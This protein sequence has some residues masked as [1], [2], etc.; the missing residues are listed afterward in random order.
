MADVPT[1]GRGAARAFIAFVVLGLGCA[2]PRTTE[3][4]AGGPA[5]ARA[6]GSDPTVTSAD[7]SGAPQNATLDIHVFGSNFDQ[8]S[9]VDF[10]RAGVVDPKLH[11]NATAFLSTAELVA[12]VSIAADAA[13]VSYDIM[14]TKSNGKKGIGTEKF[15]VLV[16]AE[17]LS[18]P[19]GF[20]YVEGMSGNGLVAGRIASSC[21]PG[22]A[23]AVWNQGQRTALPALPGTCGGGNATDVNN[24]GVAV[25]FAY[26]GTS[27]ISD[28]RWT[29]SAGTYQVEALPRL[30]DGSRGGA[31]AINEVGSV[32]AFNTAAVW[33]EST[34]WQI[35]ARPAGATSCLGQIS[36]NDANAI[37]GSCT[38]AGVQ[39]AVYWASP[40]ASP[41][42]LPVATGGSR[43]SAWDIN[44]AGVIV[45]YTIIG[46]RKTVMRPTRWTPSGGSWTV[47]FLADLGSG[48]VAYALNEAGQIAGRIDGRVNGPAF[49]DA[50]GVLRQLEGPGEALAISGAAAGPVVAGYISAGTKLAARWHP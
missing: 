29:L 32:A 35:L 47:D 50:N 30:P 41:V 6:G 37:V 17:V 2:E 9:K 49:W 3:P 5:F 8:G 18:A 28:V 24:V 36:L 26:T 31:A 16:P 20:S 12:N 33:S 45:G 22:W 4:E 7:P 40:T 11:V 19:A 39:T 27:S 46:T 10:A 34:G 25:G 1:M 44:N 14:V 13:P 21:D 42:L 38:I 23:P 15:A 48:G 43:A